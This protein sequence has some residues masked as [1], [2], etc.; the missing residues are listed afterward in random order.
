MITNAEKL[1]R[2]SAKNA[3]ADAIKRGD[4]IAARTHYNAMMVFKAKADAEVPA[5]KPWAGL[6]SRARR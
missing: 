2:E 4:L 1:G 6:Y 3:A 5:A